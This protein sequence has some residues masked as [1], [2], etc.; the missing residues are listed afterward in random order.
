MI[1]DAFL[2]FSAAQ[3]VT[4]T[5]AS[6]NVIDLGL[7]RDI[8]I[9]ESLEVDIR[10]NTTVTAAGAAT[11]NFQLQT[12]DDAAFTANVQTIVQT[13]AIPKASL[14][15]GAS[16]PLHIDRSSPYPARRYMRLNYLV[17]TGPLTAGSFTAGIVKNV[18]DP[19]ISYPSGFTII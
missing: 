18:Q 10:C 3:A 11:V 12:A 15:L 16:I 5:A 8:G 2:Q 1:Q 4:A 14:V 6:T 17:G 9:G 13:D 19:A 7:G